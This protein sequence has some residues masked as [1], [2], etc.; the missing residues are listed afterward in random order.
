MSLYNSTLVRSIAYSKLRFVFLCLLYSTTNTTTAMTTTRM[1]IHAATP[2][3]IDEAM[4]T[5]L[6]GGSEG[7]GGE[8][9]RRGE[10]VDDMGLQFSE[11]I[12][13]SGSTG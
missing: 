6:L 10:E 2:A 7:R 3:E 9:G 4:R 8:E 1:M 12:L 5:T 13:S 11:G